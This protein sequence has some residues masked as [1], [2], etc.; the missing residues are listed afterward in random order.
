MSNERKP[1]HPVAIGKVL[2]DLL[3]D[4]GIKQNVEHSR[5]FSAWRQIVGDYIADHSE[6]SELKAG[7]LRVN[8]E[9]AVW[10][11]ELAGFNNVIVDK[12]NA[13]LGKKEVR[14]LDVRISRKKHR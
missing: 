10:K 8:V 1:S 7:K 6:P 13:F 14:R 3:K 4:I 5:I 9:N 2:E 11:Q 12:V